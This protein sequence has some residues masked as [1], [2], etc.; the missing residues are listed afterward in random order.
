M[1]ENLLSSQKQFDEEIEV[2]IVMPRLGERLAYW[3]SFFYFRFCGGCL[4]C[5]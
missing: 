2:T 3:S 5:V 1:N 4:D